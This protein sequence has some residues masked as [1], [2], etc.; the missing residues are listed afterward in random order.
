MKR[1][2]LTQGEID[3][4]IILERIKNN[5]LT[6]EEA[7]KIMNLSSRQVRRKLKR[8]IIAGA[9]GLVH[10]NRGKQS[11]RAIPTPVV[12]EIFQLIEKKYS[13]LREKAGPT[14]IS[15]QLKKND[16]IIINHET[17]RRLMIKRGQW[18][19]YKK[20]QQ[21]HQWRERKHH[22]GELVQV[23]GSYHIWFGQEKSTLIAFIDDATGRIPLA[24]F[25]DR[26]ST[27]N[28]A[29]LTQDYVKQH[30][31]PLALY[32]DRG[33]TYKVNNNKDGV[34]HETHY[35]KMLHELDIELIHAR[36]PQA[37][38]RIERLFKTLQDRLVKE[39]EIARI[40]TCDAANHYLKTTYIPEHNAKF[41]VEPLVKADFHRSIDAFNL[42]SIFCLKFERIINNDYTVCFKDKWLQLDKSQKEFIRR[43]QK[44]CIHQHFDGTIDITRNDKRLIF[45][46]ITKQKTKLKSTLLKEDMRGKNRA[47]YK[48]PTSHPWRHF[49]KKQDISIELPI[50]HF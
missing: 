32:S 30:G 10:K 31:R 48:P 4:M 3:R 7:A 33:S 42:H 25:V 9:A 47:S 21:V 35:Q 49:E 16:G 8:Y 37:K 29:L 17:L 38:G 20:K 5:D 2:E 46:R 45:K 36:S 12:E 28:L 11:N 18:K 40:T 1:L 26:E 22:L 39:L 19:V 34:K 41:A 50:G 24:E 27:E 44:V 13:Q 15:D 23:D 14:F 43:G 6:Q